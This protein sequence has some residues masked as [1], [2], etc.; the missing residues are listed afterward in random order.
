MN[1]FLVYLVCTV[2]LVLFLFKHYKVNNDICILLTTTVSV[3]KD[4][5]FVAQSDKDERVQTYLKAI[6]KWL[7]NTEY[8]VVVVENS[9]YTFEELGKEKIKYKDR[10]EV[11]TFTEETLKGA[12]YMKEITNKGDHEVFAIQYA[13]EHS[14]LLHDSDFIIK[15]TGR[16]YVPGLQ[17]YLQRIYLKQYHAISQS[18]SGRC[19]LIGCSN[20]AFPMMF[21]LNMEDANGYNAHA[22]SVY[23]YRMTKKIESKELL[24]LPTFSIDPTQRGGVPEIFTTI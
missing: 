13:Y 7:Q 19:E 10:F 6:R 1:F 8:K 11:I 15:I 17:P 24:V 21:D 22:E 16:Y 9:G 5:K 3:K 14:K 23:K 4:M 20:E 2:V 12:E 18:D